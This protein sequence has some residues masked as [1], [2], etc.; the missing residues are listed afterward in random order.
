[1][2]RHL[3]KAKQIRKEIIK[4]IRKNPH[5]RV[6]DLWRTL[7]AGSKWNELRSEAA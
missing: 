2:V 6:Q 1:M 4:W 3:P 7:P 5:K